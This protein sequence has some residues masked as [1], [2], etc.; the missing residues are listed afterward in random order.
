M[1]IQAYDYIVIRKDEY[2]K[3]TKLDPDSAECIDGTKVTLNNAVGMPYGTMFTIV[4]DQVEPILQSRSCPEG[5]LRTGE[6]LSL[7][8]GH[9][10]SVDTKDNRDIVDSTSNQKLD[11]E[12]IRSL[13]ADGT[14]GE[15][16]SCY[17]GLLQWMQYVE[18]YFECCFPDC[19][20]DFF[21]T[22][23]VVYTSSGN[24]PS[25]V[26]CAAS[27]TRPEILSELIKGNANFEKKTRF[28]QDKYISKK[29]K[30]H[31]GLFSIERPCTR[32]LCELYSK[33]RPEKCLGLRFDTLC[34]ML[35]YGN[36]HAGSKVLLIETCAGLV[37]GAVLER[38]GPASL[39]GSVIQFFHGTSPPRPE[40]NPMAASAY[41][42]QVSSVSLLDVVPLL[43][44]QLLLEDQS[45]T[46]LSTPI[47][48]H[49]M[50]KEDSL[51]CMVDAIDIDLPC[52]SVMTE[53][54]QIVGTEPDPKSRDT[55]EVAA[56][57]R[58]AVRLARKRVGYE[59]LMGPNAVPADALIIAT[60]FHPVDLT[61]LLM[62]FLPVGKPVVVYAQFLQ[63]LVDLYNAIKR[64]GGVTQLRLTDSWFRTIQVLPNRTHPEVNMLAS[65]GYLLTAY[66]V[67][68]SPNSKDLLASGLISSTHSDYTQ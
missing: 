30:R 51:P 27:T 60:R 28:S 34:H 23:T 16:K 63:P 29:R 26:S 53:T 5:A 11:Y 2:F 37:L 7:V 43:T 50:K 68:P 4:G 48:V 52:E 17:I 22:N 39:G 66:T 45:V 12:G 1:L 59:Q 58:R 20:I 36:V 46:E 8:A 55:D 64:R 67:E 47:E 40:I 54:K 33:I 56:C 21:L 42:K 31:L 14:S 3:S 24:H 15:V 44:G 6:P 57:A 65:G 49:G 32:I 38:L 19:H 41:D 25:T 18:I 35:T 62:Q 10:E 9:F 13:R 61:L